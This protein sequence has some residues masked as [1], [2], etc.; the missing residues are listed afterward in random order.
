MNKGIIDN[1][2]YRFPL[3]DV[4]KLYKHGSSQQLRRQKGILLLK[5]HGSVN[6]VYYSHKQAPYGDGFYYSPWDVVG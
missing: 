6:L 4:A 1:Y 3:S 5:P 2:T